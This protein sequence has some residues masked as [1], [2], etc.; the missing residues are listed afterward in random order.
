MGNFTRVIAVILILQLLLLTGAFAQSQTNDSE[1]LTEA[2]TSTALSTNGG[3]I[4]VYHDEWAFTDKGFSTD[5]SDTKQFALNLANWFKGKNGGKFITYS[6]NSGVISQQIFGKQFFDTLTGSGYVVDKS[7]DNNFS[8]D[9]LINYDAVFLAGKPTDNNVLIEYVKSGGSV[10]LEGGACRNAYE[11]SNQW[12]TFLNYFGFNFDS[13]SYNSV[14]CNLNIVSDSS[15]FNRV[16]RLDCDNG[17]SVQKIDDS[18]NS[19]IVAAYN[20]MGICGIYESNAIPEVTP[21]P[22]PTPTPAP[23]VTN[24]G[25]IVVYHDEWAFTDK[26]FSTDPS[27]TKQFALN[28][29][30]WF[31]GKNG[32][33]F[34]TYS[35]NSGVIS[36]QIFG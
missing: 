12:K 15:I 4:V 27:D 26:G 18:T 31:K 17:S 1:T 2:A 11:E 5:P 21:T 22:T 16:N 7:T 36:Q 19:K 3:K 24:G 25:K 9:L 10:L 20:G 6:D 8:L 29:A 35:D 14:I 13:K 30:N 33:K 28:L 34:I 23:E 32:G